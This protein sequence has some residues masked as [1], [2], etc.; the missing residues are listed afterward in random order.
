M[1]KMLV[2]LFVLALILGVVENALAQWSAGVTYRQPSSGWSVGAVVGGPVRYYS[3]PV[4]Y[5]QPA[6]VVYRAPVRY[7]LPAPVYYSAPVEYT[8]PVY[9]YSAAVQYVQPGYLGY[10]SYYP[11]AYA[12]P[13]ISIGFGWTGGHAYH[14]GSYAAPYYGGGGHPGGSPAPHSGGGGH[15]GGHH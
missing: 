2:A 14:G 4:R 12:S 11:S 8:Q 3:A 10:Y 5:V 6:P 15:H 9:T 1:K 13:G 7:V